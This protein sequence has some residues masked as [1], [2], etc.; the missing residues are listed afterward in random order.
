LYYSKNH[1]KRQAKNAIL[2][3]KIY[4]HAILFSVWKIRSLYKDV[5]E[6]IE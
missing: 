1:F 5:K 4:G 3:K 2:W 6:Y